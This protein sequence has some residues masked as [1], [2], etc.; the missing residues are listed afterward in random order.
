ME[1][2]LEFL[3]ADAAEERHRTTRCASAGAA[4]RGKQRCMRIR[5][6]SGRA[7]P[8]DHGPLCDVLRRGLLPSDRWQFLLHCG[9]GKTRCREVDL[10]S[11]AQRQ[12]RRH[13]TTTLEL[14]CRRIRITRRLDL[15]SRSYTFLHHT[16]YINAARTRR[17]RP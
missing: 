3:R 5:E 4:L 1:P 10:G 15:R 8:E 2:C 11:M 16:G 7:W 17:I 13:S 6:T 12:R 9:N 14:Q